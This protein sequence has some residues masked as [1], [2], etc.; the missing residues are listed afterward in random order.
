METP[1][2]VQDD[3]E[4]S[5]ALTEDNFEILRESPVL[6]DDKFKLEVGAFALLNTLVHY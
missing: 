6:G 3:S 2:T 5:P 4:T 1:E